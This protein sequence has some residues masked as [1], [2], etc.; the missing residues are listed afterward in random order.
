MKA[1]RHLAVLS[2]MALLTS[3]CVTI[4][5]YFPAAAAEEAARVIVREVLQTP[6]EVPDS[7]P[8]GAVEPTSRW[9]APGMA[10]LAMALERAVAPAAA[11][12]APDLRIETPATDRIRASMRARNADLAPH[13][14]SG[15]VG[16]GNDGLVAIRDL[17]AVPLRDRGQVQRLVNEE[18][19]DRA[20]LYREIARANDRPDWEP[21]VR[22]TFARVW[23]EEAPSGYW[24][25]DARGNWQQ[26]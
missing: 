11:Q 4:H 18:N 14:R 8:Q 12:Q 9:G 3:A 21:K 6:D 7:E 23:V 13:L 15:A 16:F 22:E 1:M 26:K 17:S 20:A 10:L 2:L 24:Y 5:I 25:Q 19:A